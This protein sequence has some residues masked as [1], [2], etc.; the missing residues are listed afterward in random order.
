MTLRR[1]RMKKYIEVLFSEL[2]NPLRLN[3]K[4][5]PMNKVGAVLFGYKAVSYRKLINSFAYII[6]FKKQ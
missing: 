5:K 2:N 6:K 1:T 3:E 4:G